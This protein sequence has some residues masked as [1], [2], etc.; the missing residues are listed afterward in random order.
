M[1]KV[2]KQ[3]AWLKLAK[4]LDLWE[5]LLLEKI[6]WQSMIWVMDLEVLIMLRIFVTSRWWKLHTEKMDSIKYE[7]VQYRDSRSRITCINMEMKSELNPEE[8]WISI[9]DCDQRYEQVRRRT[10]ERGKSIHFEEMV[11]STERPFATKRKGQ[12]N[13]PLPS[14][15]KMFV[16]VDQPTEVERH[17]PSTSS[18]RDLCHLVSRILRRQGSR[19]WWCNG[20][21][22]IV[23][24]VC[25]RNGRVRNG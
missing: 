3:F 8:W 6:S 14:F 9:L 22:Y 10:V 5:R 17:L 20:L 15:S 23:T 16:P 7:I 4:M 11:T 25:R 21:E 19:R 2:A 18:I 1:T 24:C 13:P 12:S